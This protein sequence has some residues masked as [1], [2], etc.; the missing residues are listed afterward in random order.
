MHA[1]HAPACSR[2]SAAC[3]P[4]RATGV[5]VEGTAISVGVTL[6]AYHKGVFQFSVCRME[7]TSEAAEQAQFT[8]ECLD[9]HVLVRST[10]QC[11]KRAA[12]AASRTCVRMGKSSKAVGLI[13]PRNAPPAAGCTRPPAAH[14]LAP[15][16]S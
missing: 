8:Q 14:P 6:T 7:G 1:R 4:A 5:Y 13:G 9:R 16:L 11:S 2:P 3:R 15:L 12:Q 10:A